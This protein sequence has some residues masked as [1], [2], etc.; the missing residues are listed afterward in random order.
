M[1]FERTIDKVSAIL[2]PPFL[3][4]TIISI[5]AGAARLQGAYEFYIEIAKGKIPM[6]DL[7]ASLITISHAIL[8]NAKSILSNVCTLNATTD[9]IAKRQKRKREQ[10]SSGLLAVSRTHIIYKSSVNIVKDNGDGTGD[11]MWWRFQ[12]K[13]ENEY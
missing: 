1:K 11:V 5:R 4:L 6:K 12:L 9:S 3:P 2:S 13:L 7:H 10:K 8:A